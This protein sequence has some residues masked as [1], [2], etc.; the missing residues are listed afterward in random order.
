MT[1]FQFILTANG[2][3]CRIFKVN[4]FATCKNKDRNLQM[5]IGHVTILVADIT[6]HFKKQ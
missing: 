2:A 5:E 6:I 1:N 3:F 4:L